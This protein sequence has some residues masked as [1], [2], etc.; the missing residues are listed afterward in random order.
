M[1]L[2]NL[3]IH[4]LKEK[5]A[6]YLLRWRNDPVAFWVEALQAEKYGYPTPHQAEILW[7]L[8]KHRFVAVSSGHGI[9]K[10]RTLAVA[11]VW[12]LV[13]NHVPGQPIT[14]QCTAPTSN[15]LENVLWKELC[16]VK[17]HLVE[18]IADRFE[19]TS[20]KFYDKEKGG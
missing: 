1:I 10:T 13:C 11:I 6:H 8:K 12:H 14:I 9:G 19:H 18:W 5:L 2:S 4:R 17:T 20:E 3:D 16:L 15:T 7:N